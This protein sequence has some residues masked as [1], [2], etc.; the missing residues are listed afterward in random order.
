VSRL[1]DPQLDAI[2]ALQFSVAWAGEGAGNP[3]RLGWW[4]TDL[5]DRE[6]GGDLFSR[7]VPKTAAWASLGLVRQ[8]ASR[9]DG[10]LRARHARGDRIWTLFHFGFAVDEQLSDRL[11]YHRQHGH[12]PSEVLG[13]YFWVRPAFSQAEFESQLAKLGDPRVEIVPGGRKISARAA[14]PIEGAT[15]LAAA[16]RPLSPSYPLP[17]L[18]MAE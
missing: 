17:F 10:E 2:L 14:S 7:L 11:A 6:G 8:A 5:V 1:P 4:K 16:L 3:P 18:E 15:L 13:E 12:V 9:V